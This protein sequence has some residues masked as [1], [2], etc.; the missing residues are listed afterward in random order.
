MIVV[1]LTRAT[2]ALT[3]SADSRT[4]ALQKQNI[5]APKDI[6]GG[7][8]PEAP[9][10]QKEE[11]RLDPSEDPFAHREGKTLLWRDINMTLVRIFV[12]QNFV[13]DV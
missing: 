2:T 13:G 10:L 3:K 4:Q 9:V 8:I 5:M 6:E 1:K 7:E 11:S 12:F